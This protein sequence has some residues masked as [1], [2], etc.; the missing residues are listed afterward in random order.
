[1]QPVHPGQGR[2]DVGRDPV[3]GLAGSIQPESRLEREQVLQQRGPVVAGRRI[4]GLLDRFHDDERGLLVGR[5]LDLEAA[6]PGPDTDDR[7]DAVGMLDGGVEGVRAT[8]RVADEGRPLD[9]EGVEDRDDIGTLVEIDVVGLRPAEPAR[10]VADDA[11][12]GR[13]EERGEGVPRAQVRDPGVEEVDRRDPRGRPRRRR[14]GG[15][16]GR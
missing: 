12:A 9:P 1:M 8:H 16:R 5:R 10:V 4:D 15:R 13:D 14:R 2:A 7:D 6:Q 11:V 3:L